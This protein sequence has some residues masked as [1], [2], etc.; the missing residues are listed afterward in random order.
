[1]ANTTDPA[2]DPNS[3]YVLIGGGGGKALLF[4]SGKMHRVQQLHICF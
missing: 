3:S 4:H 1:M 2:D